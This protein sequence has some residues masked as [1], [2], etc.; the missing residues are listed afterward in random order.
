MRKL[1]FIF[2]V[3]LMFFS[4]GNAK[5]KEGDK[6][7]DYRLLADNGK[8]INLS[9][10]RGKWIILYFYP[11]DNTPGCTKEAKTFSDLYDEFKKENAVIFGINTDDI[12]SHQKFKKKHNLKITLL[13]D[14][15]GKVAKDFGVR[16]ILGFCH[17]DTILI[18]TEGKVE[19]IYR[20]VDPEGNPKEIL[21]YIRNKN[22][23]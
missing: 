7:P 15:K 20:G 18:N 9:N 19:K 14:K 1:I 4:F 13:S 23:K 2:G 8:Y 21:N 10:Y 16:V 6:V 17:R 3:V 11:K 12:K 22:K 5:I